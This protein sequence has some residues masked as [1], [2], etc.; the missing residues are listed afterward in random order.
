VTN[1]LQTVLSTLL[2]ERLPAPLRCLPRTAAGS[3][4]TG[5]S[6]PRRTCGQK[7]ARSQRWDP[8][9]SEWL[10]AGGSGDG[11]AESPALPSCQGGLEGA[12]DGR[13]CDSSASRRP[14]ASVGGGRVGGH[15]VGVRCSSPGSSFF[16]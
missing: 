2:L 9:D 7:L 1:P 11:V 8:G 10:S 16:P 14:W 6:H 12:A 5:S 15:P 13:R 4:T 3:G